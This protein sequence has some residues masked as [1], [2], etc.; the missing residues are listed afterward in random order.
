VRRP[1]APKMTLR[2]A[3]DDAGSRECGEWAVCGGG[4][5]APDACSD[6]S[7]HVLSGILGARTSGT[8]ERQQHM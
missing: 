1:Q 2:T 8:R 6:H 3:E 5:G 4:G 7:I